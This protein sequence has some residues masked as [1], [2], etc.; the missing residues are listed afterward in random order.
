MSKP[1]G[2]KNW[3]H[4]LLERAIKSQTASD[5]YQKLDF[6]KRAPDERVLVSSYDP[7]EDA[8]IVTDHIVR[9]ES[10]PFAKGSMRTCYRI[11]KMSA[12][13]DNPTWENASAYVAKCYTNTPP[14]NPE[15]NKKM[16]EMDVRVQMMAKRYAEIYNA[17]HPPKKIDVM[18]VLMFEFVDRPGSPAFCVERFL[19]GEYIKYNSNVGFADDHRNT[20]QAF[21]HFSFERSNG[22]LLI[23]DIQGVGDLYTDPQIHALDENALGEGNLGLSGYA[24]FFHT[25]SCNSICRH[26]D[27]K[28]FD[29]YPYLKTLSELEKRDPDIFNAVAVNS[30]TKTHWKAHSN[31]SKYSMRSSPAS[32]GLKSAREPSFDPR[33]A[34]ATINGMIKNL[35]EDHKWTPQLKQSYELLEPIVLQWKNKDADDKM[36][37]SSDNIAAVQ[38]AT[39][40][41]MQATADNMKETFDRS[42]KDISE[43]NEIIGKIHRRIALHFQ[44][45]DIPFQVPT[46]PT[47]VA[48]IILF[49]YQQAAMHDCVEA[50]LV[51]ANIYNDLTCEEMNMRLGVEKDIVLSVV[52]AEKAAKL[53]SKIACLKVSV[54]YDSVN[55]PIEAEYNG[56]KDARTK[57]PDWHTHRFLKAFEAYQKALEFDNWPQFDLDFR[58]Y[59]LSADDH[60][61]YASMARLVE[62]GGHGLDKSTA[63][64]LEF[65]QEAATAAEIAFKAKRALHYYEQVQRVS[66]LMS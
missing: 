18:Q 13:I 27:L 43:M 32:S 7:V 3:S 40:K 9:M 12:F 2:T 37:L 42:N 11:K 55:N 30:I 34:L 31:F 15:F 14:D 61:I 10:E 17:Q 47:E 53:G 46:S 26:L 50:C 60:L 5:P 49:H 36:E 19:E 23:V 28:P 24:L 1:V 63:K 6:W 65:W 59:E 22:Q 62:A 39:S 48:A 66:K 29:H 38:K 51:L 54:A 56:V 35:P 57:L 20:P 4:Q 25:H 64:A 21:S 52:Y 33:T 58:G 8:W 44:A 41:R 16:V 45:N